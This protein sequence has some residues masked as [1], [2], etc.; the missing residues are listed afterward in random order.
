MTVGDTR[1]ILPS[2]SNCRQLWQV[3]KRC[4]WQRPVARSSLLVQPSRHVQLLLQS[5][6]LENCFLLSAVLTSDLAFS[7]SPSSLRTFLQ[8]EGLLTTLAYPCAFSQSVFTHGLSSSH[9]ISHF[10]SSLGHNGHCCVFWV[11]LGFLGPG[12]SAGGHFPR[13]P[14][15]FVHNHMLEQRERRRSHRDCGP[16]VVVRDR[17]S[18]RRAHRRAQ[19][20]AQCRASYVD[21]R[22][23]ATGAHRPLLTCCS[24][25]Q[26]GFA[27][28]KMH[29]SLSLF[30]GNFRFDLVAINRPP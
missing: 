8:Q 23:C 12:E 11:V 19:C 9:Q 28:S 29:L 3:A 17:T 14:S 10:W 6:N 27:T 5:L 4:S 16:S 20:R 21:V 18:S 13:S 26:A 2:V 24:S 30:F 15:P 1:G 7:L 22:T 25:F